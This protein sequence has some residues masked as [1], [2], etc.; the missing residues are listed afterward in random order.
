MEFLISI[1]TTVA[2]CNE[3]IPIYVAFINGEQGD[4]HLDEDEYINVQPCTVDFLCDL[5]YKGEMNDS[6]TVA[7]VLAYKDRYKN[8]D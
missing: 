6:K 7:A 8:R 5:I 2:F 4:Q 1:C 3:K